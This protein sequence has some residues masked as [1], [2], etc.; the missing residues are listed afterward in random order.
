MD[1]VWL[2]MGSLVGLLAVGMAAATAHLVAGPAAAIAWRAVQMQGWHALVL[3][4][5]GLWAPRG[6]LLAHLAGTLFVLGT[7]VFC[8]AV[9][10]V[11]LG[12]LHLGPL[13]PAGGTMLMLG[14]AVLGISILR[15]RA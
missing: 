10:A 14:W 5:T 12:G 6:G 11:A 15:A 1:R 4:V 2:G 13:A 8:G 3:L 9:Y 7:V